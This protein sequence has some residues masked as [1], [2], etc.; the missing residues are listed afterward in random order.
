MRWL[1]RDPLEEEG[2]LNLC[3][4]CNNAPAF[5]IDISGLGRWNFNDV[6]PPFLVMGTNIVVVTYEMD[7]SERK[8]CNRVIVRRYVR[9]FLTGGMVGIYML[10]GSDEQSF[11]VGNKGF[12]PVD[13]PEG[14]GFRVPFT[15]TGYRTRWSWDFFFEA[16]CADGKNKGKTLSFARKFYH[17]VG[18]RNGADFPKG[19]FSDPPKK[20]PDLS[21][22]DS[23]LR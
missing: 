3:C 12:A 8:C 23:L 4:F 15:Q 21:L 7:E 2:G 10:D 14:P 6:L 19:V 1:N 5:H 22:E 17:A 20:W 9:K 11:S 18:H 16:V 13:W